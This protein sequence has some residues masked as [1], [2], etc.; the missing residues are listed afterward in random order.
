MVKV[1]V[2]ASSSSGNSTFIGTDNTRILID[3]GLNRKEIFARLAAIGEDPAKLD[4]IFVTHE[5]TDH[6]CGLPVMMRALGSKV[7]VFLTHL[8]AP[9]IEW[10]TGEPAVET[11]QAGATID[12]GGLSV[13]SFTIPHDAEDPVAYA[14]TVEGIKISIATDLGY[15][16]DSVKFHLRGSHFLL[17]ESNHHPDLLKVGPYPWHIKQRILSRKGHLSNEAACE[18][19]SSELPAETQMLVLGHLSEQ[20]NTIWEAELSAV[21]ALEKRGLKPRLV[22]AE[23]RKQSEIFRL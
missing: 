17:L 7:P 9:K 18:Y 8:T 11:F 6:I 22:V 4:A 3:A 1:C 10:G 23:P 15:I 16:P 13:A 2:L 20:N 5:H 14:V 21:Q 19:I 12:L